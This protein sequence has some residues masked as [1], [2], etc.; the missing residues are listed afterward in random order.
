MKLGMQVGLGPGH[1]DVG[2]SYPERGTVPPISAH[3]RCSQT[4]GWIKM[5]LGMEVVLAP[6]DFVLDGTQLPLPKKGQAPNFRPTSI[7]AKRLYASGY[8]LVRT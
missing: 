3:V 2:L 6:G 8:H 4:A 7:V 5:P 1:I